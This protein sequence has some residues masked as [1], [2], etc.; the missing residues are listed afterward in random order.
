MSRRDGNI[1]ELKLNN[2]PDMI[3][4]YKK[5]KDQESKLHKENSEM[6]DEIKKV[7]TSNNLDDFSSNN[8]T[9]KIS[10]TQK[11]D[12]NELK[13]IDIL[14]DNLSKEDLSTV[15]RTKEYID[16]DALEK[17]VYSGKFDIGKLQCCRTLGKEVVTL[18]ITKKK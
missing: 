18:R 16:D 7:M 11:E 9:A 8:W 15:V 14:K 4:V 3:D 10:V 1:S 6:G 12:F 2:L 17:L 13:A 5:G